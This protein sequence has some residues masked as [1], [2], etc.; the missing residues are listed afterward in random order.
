MI[1]IA[2][3]SFS[4]GAHVIHM[5]NFLGICDDMSVWSWVHVIFGL[6]FCDVYCLVMVICWTYVLG[7]CMHDAC[8][9]CL[10]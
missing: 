9:S 6:D 10:S 4:L 5:L 1:N 8:N 3:Y 2:K 7:K